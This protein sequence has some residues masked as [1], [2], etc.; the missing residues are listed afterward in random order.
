MGL[1]PLAGFFGKL[2]LFHQLIVHGHYWLI[3]YFIGM[4]CFAIFYFLRVVVY[5]VLPREE[6]VWSTKSIFYGESHQ[7]IDYCLILVTM[8]HILFFCVMS[9]ILVKCAVGSFSIYFFYKGIII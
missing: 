5:I 1:P 8:F 3:W 9:L 7:Y 2:V 6:K 4:S